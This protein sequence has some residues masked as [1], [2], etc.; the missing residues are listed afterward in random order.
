MV[1][2]PFKLAVDAAAV[3]GQL[4][5]ITCAALLELIPRDEPARVLDDDV[6]F[7]EEAADAYLRSGAPDCGLGA[8]AGPYTSPEYFAP[9]ALTDGTPF[10]G[11][12]AAPYLQPI[13]LQPGDPVGTVESGLISVAATPAEDVL[14]SGGQTHEMPPRPRISTPG[15]RRTDSD[16]LDHLIALVEDV[17]NLLPA[18]ADDEA[19]PVR[20]P[21]AGAA[22]RV[23]STASVDDAGRPNVNWQLLASAQRA[24]THWLAGASC[25]QTAHWQSVADELRFSARELRDQQDQLYRK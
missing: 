1:T 11:I 22:P 14:R 5:G 24:I 7:D 25:T 13:L 2:N 15:P 17:R 18:P 4:A 20:G 10:D 9:P 23:D 8:A 12:Y 16:R 3:A 6:D 21:S 19:R